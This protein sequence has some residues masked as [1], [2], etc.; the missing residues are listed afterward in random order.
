M[1]QPLYDKLWDSHVVHVEDEHQ[2]EAVAGNFDALVAAAE[3]LDGAAGEGGGFVEVGFTQF[4]A[5]RASESRRAVAGW[6][7]A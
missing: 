1:P 4:V 3:L 6:G 5:H 2:G 7:G